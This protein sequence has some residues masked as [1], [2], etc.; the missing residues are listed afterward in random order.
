MGRQRRRWPPPKRPYPRNWRKVVAVL[1]RVAGGC[2]EWCGSTDDLTIHHMGVPYVAG[3]P[4]CRRD[5]HDLRREN[6]YCLCRAC[7]EQIDTELDALD[8]AA[9]RKMAR[10]VRKHRLLGI[11]TGLALWT[12][13]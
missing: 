10:K 3:R 6:L 7:H 2:C 9:Q 8:Q 4:G 5:K 13:E 1:K 12:D 11:G